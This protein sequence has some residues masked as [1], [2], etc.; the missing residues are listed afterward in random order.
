MA[1]LAE[2]AS[3]Y[4]TSEKLRFIELMNIQDALS[5]WSMFFRIRK[6]PR[7]SYIYM[8]YIYADL[9]TS[10]TTGFLF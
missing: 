1:S 4:V 8:D 3:M 10:N 5:R 7:E 9:L 2:M 6:A